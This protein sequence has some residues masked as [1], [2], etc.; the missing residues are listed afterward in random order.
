M[1][2]EKFV[3][4]RGGDSQVA[5]VIR[6][7]DQVWKLDHALPGQGRD[8]DDRR[9][10]EELH[11]VA[12]LL[13][14]LVD[15]VGILFDH[16][17]FVDDDNDRATGLVRVPGDVGV[18]RGHA[19]DRVDQ[20]QR[21]IG[22]FD[23]LARHDD[24]KLLLH[25]GRL[26]LA[27]NAGGVYQPEPDLLAAFPDL[28][29][30]H[31]VYGVARRARDV[32]NDHALL[33]EQFVDQR[34]FAD[35]RTPDDRDVDLAPFALGDLDRGQPFDHR[36]EQVAHAH[37]VFGGNREHVFVP[38]A[39]KFASEIGD[40]RGIDLVRGDE[41]RLVQ[42]PQPPR[43]FLIDRSYPLA[44]VDHEQQQARLVNRRASLFEDVGRDHRLVVGHDAP[45]VH[46]AKG[47][48]LPFGLAVYSVA[49][50]S[51]NVADYRAPRADQ[52]VEQSRFTHV[53]AADDRHHRDRDR[54]FVRRFILCLDLRH[55]IKVAK[56]GVHSQSLLA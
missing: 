44:R 3:Q 56:L 29:F 41:D 51:G 37:A 27:A 16:V 19:F 43:Q 8:K 47:V 23:V 22:A 39:V 26:A 54:L 36:V 31:A 48:V 2:F 20:E 12:D 30:K 40:L 50:H 5:R 34:R 52:T 45:G 6:P 21:D 25:P 13:F 4:L 14:V 17:P 10:I 18:E 35:V 33:P 1:F 49:R 46:Y 53:R 7:L 24:R 11:R 28:R 55:I 32:R 38:E 42:R 15:R 9:V